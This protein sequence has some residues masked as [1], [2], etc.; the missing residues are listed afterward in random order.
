[1]DSKKSSDQIRELKLQYFSFRQNSE[2]RISKT[3]SQ[4]DFVD[5]KG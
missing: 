2:T 4:I 5:E 1:M 3:E